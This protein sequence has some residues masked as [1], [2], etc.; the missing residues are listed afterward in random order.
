MDFYGYPGVPEL[1]NAKCG[2]EVQKVGLYKLTHVFQIE[3]YYF[4][5]S[6][7]YITLIA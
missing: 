4:P 2:K 5:H 7:A 1:F 3:M 6:P